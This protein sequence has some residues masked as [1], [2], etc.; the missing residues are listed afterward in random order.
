MEKALKQY[1]KKST[2]I[3]QI[4]EEIVDFKS[5]TYVACVDPP[6]KESFFINNGVKENNG[7][8]KKYFWRAPIHQKFLE[9]TTYS[10]MDIY[11][12]MTHQL[13]S[14]WK[15]SLVYLNGL[16]YDSIFL[17]IFLYIKIYHQTFSNSSLIL[18]K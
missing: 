16:V 13:G 4:R 7:A 2:T 15:I 10:A 12:N 11:M 8:K 18:L 6:L 5:P 14:D 1:S 9:N 17:T 3:G